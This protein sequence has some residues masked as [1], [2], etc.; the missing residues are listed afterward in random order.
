MT[1][2]IVLLFFKLTSLKNVLLFC[3]L[4]LGDK[5]IRLVLK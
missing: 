1:F 3:R 5:K 4:L 2:K